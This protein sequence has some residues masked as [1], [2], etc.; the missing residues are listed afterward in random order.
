MNYVLQVL[1]AVVGTISFAVLFSVAK[2]QRIYCGITAGIGWT[3]YLITMYFSDSSLLSTTLSAITLTVIS[4]VLSAKRKAP[5]TLFLLCGIFTLV[6]GAGLY[7]TSFHMFMNHSE[8]AFV[9]LDMTVKIA[10]AIAFGI[11][12]GYTLPPSLFGWGKGTIV[13]KP[14][15]QHHYSEEH[16]D[17]SYDGSF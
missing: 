7:Y 1:A 6:P 4:R 12:V 11:A 2:K 15:V 16:S 5:A 8:Q 3:V 10:L 9:S 13:E 14:I 17:D